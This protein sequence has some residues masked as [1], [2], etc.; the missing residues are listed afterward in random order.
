MRTTIEVVFAVDDLARVVVQHV[1]QVPEE[2]GR[3]DQDAPA[4]SRSSRARPRYAPR[5]GGRTRSLPAPSASPSAPCHASRS[6]RGPSSCR[7]RRFAG[8]ARA[9]ALRH[10]RRTRS[11]AARRSGDGGVK[12]RAAELS[13]TTTQV[14]R[15]SGSLSWLRKDHD[16]RTAQGSAAG[17]DASRQSCRRLRLRAARRIRAALAHAPA[18]RPPHERDRA[19][20]P[21]GRTS[22]AT[23]GPTGPRRD[24]RRIPARSRPCARASR[25]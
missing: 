20:P 4:R 5:A 18:L 2:L 19:G 21:A 1:A 11:P 12:M 23:A 22:A 10:A 17:G 24:R 3:R 8:P 14:A 25:T 16:R 7:A 15:M 9:S 13:A 6:R